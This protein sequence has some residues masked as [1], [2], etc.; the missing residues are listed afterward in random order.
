MGTIPMNVKTRLLI[1][2]DPVELLCSKKRLSFSSIKTKDPRPLSEIKTTKEFMLKTDQ[3]VKM[4]NL[5][6]IKKR[7]K[8]SILA[9]KLSK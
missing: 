8:S 2:I 5:K 3:V 6:K 9:T 1:D 4:S 7:N